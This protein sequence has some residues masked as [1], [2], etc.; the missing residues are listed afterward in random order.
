MGPSFEKNLRKTGVNFYEPQ[1]VSAL[2]IEV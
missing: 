1:I 2:K